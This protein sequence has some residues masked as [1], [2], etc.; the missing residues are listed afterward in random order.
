MSYIL[1]KDFNLELSRGRITGMTG[2]NKFGRNIAVSTTETVVTRTGLAYTGFLTTAST[3]RV[4]AG[5]N[6]ND[7]AAGTGAQEITFEGLDANFASVTAT[8]ATA[9]A[10]ASASTTQTFIRV[11]RCYVSDGKAG[12]YSTGVNGSNTGD[13]DIETTTSVILLARISALSGQT[14]LAVSTIP[15]GYTGYLTKFEADVPQ[16]KSCTIRLYQRR[17]GDD[18]TTPYSPRRIIHTFSELV[19]GA[20]KEW[21]PYYASFPEKTDIWVTA[22]KDAAGTAAVDTEFD[23]IL[24][25]NSI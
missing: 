8:I 25:S 18:A 3:I 5:G 14:Q 13:I 2:I 6:A 22:Q 4:R 17:N 9:G 1:Q 23:L 11:T 19:G 20:V 16:S 24:V 21:G 12:T 7:T 10:S 15:A